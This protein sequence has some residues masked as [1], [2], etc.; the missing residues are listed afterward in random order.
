[1]E[2]L[3]GVEDKG[4]AGVKAKAVAV[5]AEQERDRGPAWVVAPRELPLFAS[6]PRAAKRCPIDKACRVW[7]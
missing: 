4:K 6:A 7:R 2:V 1:L 3:E 5:D